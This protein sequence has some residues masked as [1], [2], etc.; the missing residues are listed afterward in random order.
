[1]EF[2]ITSAHIHFMVEI[3]TVLF[4][5]VVGIEIGALAEGMIAAAV[6]GGEIEDGGGEGGGV[7]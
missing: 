2:A 7:G 5:F 1:M 3:H 6:F 4:W